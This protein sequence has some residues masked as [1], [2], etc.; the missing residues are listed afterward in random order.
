VRAADQPKH[1]D[2]LGYT[3]TRFASL[4]GVHGLWTVRAAGAGPDAHDAF[5]LISARYV[6]T[7]KASSAEQLVRHTRVLA[8]HRELEEVSA[9]WAQ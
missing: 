1:G 6:K 4:A 7:N 5:L 9:R 8:T 2:S 3:C